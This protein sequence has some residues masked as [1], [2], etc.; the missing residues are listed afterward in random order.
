METLRINIL[1][2]KAK[3]LL[4]NLADLNLIQISKNQDST[5]ISSLLKSLR[6]NS[7]EAPSIEEIT[8][9]VEEVRAARYEK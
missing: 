5:A 2:P 6:K 7:S 1:N 8:K 9:D 4:Q 3:K